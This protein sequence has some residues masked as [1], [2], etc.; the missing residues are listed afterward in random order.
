[1]SD[2]DESFLG[3]TERKVGL[4]LGPT[5][6]SPAWEGGAT[7]PLTDRLYRAVWAATWLL[8]AYWTPAP[9]RGWRRWLLRC[10]G[11]R[12]AS[13]ANVYGSARIWSPANLCMGD[14]A[15]IG[16]GA[17]IYSMAPITI[18]PFAIVSQRAHLCAGTHDVEDHQFQLR[19]RPIQVG[20]RAWIAAEAFVGP[21]VTVGDGAV[22]GARSCAMRNLD[23][24]TVYTGNPATSLRVRRIRFDDDTVG[25][26]AC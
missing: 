19:T 21:G 24:W 3:R 6:R 7:F 9:L 13:T 8:L 25:N 2:I 26:C 10:F 22:L 16:P 15:T 20:S 11:A 14:H 5:E 23:A 17:I 18:G 12:L 4:A 1:M